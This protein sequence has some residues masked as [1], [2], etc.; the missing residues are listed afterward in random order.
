[1]ALIKAIEKVLLE[2]EEKNPGTVFDQSFI[3][4]HTSDTRI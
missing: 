4:E 2:E 3:S 1:M